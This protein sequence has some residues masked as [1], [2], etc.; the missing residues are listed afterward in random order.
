MKTK[1][2][3]FVT[4]LAAAVFGVGCSSFQTTET[5]LKKGL[6]TYYPFNGNAKDVS[7]NNH[8]GV[9]KGASLSVDRHGRPSQAYFFDG[10]DDYIEVNDSAKLDFGSQGAISFWMQPLTWAG[11]SK[12]VVSKKSSDGEPGVVIYRNTHRGGQ[13]TFRLEPV[14]STS[15][16]KKAAKSYWSADGWTKSNVEIKRW[17][18]WCAVWNG[19]II[20]WFRNG[21]LDASHTKP[22]IEGTYENSVPLHIGHSQT[23]Q[24]GAAGRYFHGSLDEVRIYN[25]A[26]STA[27][28]KALY[29]L[30]K[31]KGK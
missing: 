16:E 7:G 5:K 10:Q 19:A 21:K 2:T 27:E 23:K 4:V 6:V 11:G 15:E 22:W 9:G 1:L 26:L 29:D 20:A 28:V 17:E 12:G 30:E 25:R 14:G 24:W 8:H 18:H 3:L 31:P 13:I